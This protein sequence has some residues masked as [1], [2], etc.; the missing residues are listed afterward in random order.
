VQKY[1]VV[2]VLGVF[3]LVAVSVI[4]AHTVQSAAVPLARRAAA[5]LFVFGLPCL[6]FALAW[7]GVLH[8]HRTLVEGLRK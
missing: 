3:A 7:V 5:L 6:V 1:V 8:T 2:A 4:T